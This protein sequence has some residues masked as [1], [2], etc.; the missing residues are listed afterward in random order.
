MSENE[1]KINFQPTSQDESTNW[2]F[3]DLMA[4]CMIVL[5]IGLLITLAVLGFNIIFASTG[6]KFKE[7]KELFGI[8]LPLIATW[9]GTVLAFYF[10]KDNFIAA[11]QSVRDLVKQVTSTEDMLQEL[12][13]SDVMLKPESFPYKI[14]E[15][16]DKFENCEIQIQDLIRSMDETN[17][18]R[19]PLLEKNTLKFVFLFYR[20]TLERFLIGCKNS[21][22]LLEDK[23]KTGKEDDLTIKNIF[24]S[25]F[26]L[27]KDIRE[28]TKKKKF[29][30]VN[31]TLAEVRQL[32][33]DNTICQDVFI[34]KTGNKDEKVEGWITN[35]IIIEKAELFKKAGT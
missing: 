33:Q 8:L 6:D 20:S 22:I 19:L 34:T 15:N 17:V 3:R 32:M 25:N 28:L 2:S 13:V 31:A 26:Q 11:N 1:K 35:S 23:N 9:V 5:S 30:P 18:E 4:I 21:K 16:L 24:E 14:V 7:I 12:K 29:L 27:I 10:S